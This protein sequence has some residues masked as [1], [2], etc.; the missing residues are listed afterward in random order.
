M[1]ACV[2]YPLGQWFAGSGGE[3]LDM[4]FVGL[5]V[6]SVF[7]V[8]LLSYAWPDERPAVFVVLPGASSF[9]TPP[10]FIAVCGAV[11]L[12]LAASVQI[13]SVVP[14]IRE[15]NLRPVDAVLP[16][17]VAALAGMQM[18]LAWCG[19][20]VHLRPEGLW[21]RTLAGSVRVPWEALTPG[22]PQRPALYA[23]TL[24][25]TYAR[26]DL[27]RRRGL[28]LRPRRLP[29]KTVH[30]WFISDAIRYYLAHPEHRAAIGSEAE[31]RRLLDA[32]RDKPANPTPH[33]RS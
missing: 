19:F 12:A 29:I 32:L 18:V 10:S 4:L 8:M 24:A 30:A 22:Y 2:G 17:L 27:V 23:E 16:V 1:A 31:Y 13:G 28:V 21:W 25:L 33:T 11:A 14:S 6:G 9:S 7:L 3:I 20:L 5:L 15:H 26:P